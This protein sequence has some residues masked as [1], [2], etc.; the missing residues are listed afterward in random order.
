MY[1]AISGVQKEQNCR[2]TTGTEDQA[3]PGRARSR[4]GSSVTLVRS[5]GASPCLPLRTLAVL[6]QSIFS[7]AFPVTNATPMLR[8]CESRNNKWEQ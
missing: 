5:H 8:V 3:T 1:T 4:E 6:T 7:L 2:E